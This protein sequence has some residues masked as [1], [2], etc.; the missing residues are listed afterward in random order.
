MKKKRRL[1]RRRGVVEAVGGSKR[2]HQPGGDQIIQRLR[3]FDFL[4]ILSKLFF[5][6]CILKSRRGGS[7][8][9]EE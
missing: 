9:I 3:F 8:K 7:S 1:K 2:L 4:L 5:T 6:F